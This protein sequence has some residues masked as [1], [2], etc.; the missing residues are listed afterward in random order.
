[1]REEKAKLADITGY[2]VK[3]TAREEKR[4]REQDLVVIQRRK[5][6]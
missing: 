6:P 4:E 3:L 5:K 2:R 1:M